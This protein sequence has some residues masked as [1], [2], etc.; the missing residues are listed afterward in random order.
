MGP[1]VMA[2]PPLGRLGGFAPTPANQEQQGSCAGSIDQSDIDGRAKTAYYNVST[3]RTEAKARVAPRAEPQKGESGSADMLPYFA[4]KA[5]AERVN[6]GRGVLVG[7]LLAGAL[8][9]GIFALVSFF[10]R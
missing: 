6:P 5:S 3:M 1:L 8:W 9:I 4:E 2:W 7:L 10:K